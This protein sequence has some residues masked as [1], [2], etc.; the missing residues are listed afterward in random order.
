MKDAEFLELLNL[1]VDNEI[2]TGQAERLEAEV[3]GN[4]QRRKLYRQYCMMHKGCSLL[5]GSFVDEAAPVQRREVFAASEA[6]RFWGWGAIFAGGGLAAA[7]CLVAL[8]AARTHVRSLP[9]PAASQVTIARAMSPD[10][11]VVLAPQ[12]T[13]NAFP[14]PFSG[15][16]LTT[17]FNVRTWNTSA[18]EPLALTRSDPLAWTD[19]IQFAPVAR[20]SLYSAPA[21]KT[22]PLLLP[23]NPA[24]SPIAPTPSQDVESAAFQFQ[25]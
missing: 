3:T 18:V 11:Q 7:A 22:V 10:V 25:R 15:T 8:V 12:R 1:Y 14:A 24:A 19:D 13:V 20:G 17:A 23:A 2:S 6:G 4:P 16:E 21:L 5:S 9:A